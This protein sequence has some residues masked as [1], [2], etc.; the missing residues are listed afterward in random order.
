MSERLLAP[1]RILRTALV[2][3]TRCARWSRFA[4]STPDSPCD[5]ECNTIFSR[6]VSTFEEEQSISRAVARMFWG[7]V[8]PF[9]W[10]VE[11]DGL[12]ALVL[13]AFIRLFLRDEEPVL[14]AEVEDAGIDSQPHDACS[15]PLAISAINAMDK[16][17]EGQHL[18]IGFGFHNLPGNG[19]KEKGAGLG[20]RIQ[21]YLV[22]FPAVGQPNKEM[23]GKGQRQPLV[24]RDRK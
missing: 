1:P 16:V 10:A 13:R 3:S 5:S 9:P 19:L 6:S 7:G 24:A 12:A 14:S 4:I 2:I 15:L 22:H 18:F 21:G 8:G 17:A 11:F 20:R 23:P